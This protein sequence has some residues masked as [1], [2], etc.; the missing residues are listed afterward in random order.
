MV[1]KRITQAVIFIHGIGEQRPM[2]TLRRFVEAVLPDPPQ[3][4]EKYF[5]KPDRLSESFELR[6]LQDRTQPRTH[7]YEYYWAYKVSGTTFGHIWNWLS[8]LLF[9][10]PKRIPKHL[11]PYW[12]LSWILIIVAAIAAVLGLVETYTEFTARFPTWLVSA[13]SAIIFSVIQSS[14]LYRLGDAARYLSP[15]PANIKLRHEIRADGV[16]LLRNIHESGDYD[17]VIL[18]GHSLGSVIA[19]DILNYY[20]QE[21]NTVYTEPVEADQKALE[22]VEACGEVLYDR[23]SEATLQAYTEAQKALWWELRELGHPWL[24]TDLVTLGSPLAH[25]ALLMAEDEDDLKA[26]QRQRELPIN[27][28]E[29]EIE[30]RA[31]EERKCYS[32]RVWDP[33]P[34][35]VQE[36]EKVRPPSAQ[37]TIILKKNDAAG[38]CS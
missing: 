6:K 33:Y 32:Y 37:A 18:V 36:K 25:A 23:R 20:W 35:D 19:Y 16:K 1:Q 31:G 24:V 5:S 22:A 9:R 34:G 30:T 3:G 4:G 26:R 17:R 28:P 15:R 7:F 13:V 29:A 38:S 14:I 12:Y 27:P 8:S 10:W 2:E 11:K 21:V